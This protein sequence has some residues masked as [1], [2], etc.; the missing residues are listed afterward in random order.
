MY[1]IPYAIATPSRPG[2]RF[3]SSFARSAMVRGF[4]A[5]IS[6]PAWMIE[7]RSASRMPL[8]HGLPRRNPRSPSRMNIGFIP[9]ASRAVTRWIVLRISEMR[10]A[11][12]LTTMRE[13]SC[14]RKLCSRVQSPTY[15]RLGACA[16]MPTSRSMVAAAEARLRSRRSWRASSARFSARRSRVGGRWATGPFSFPLVGGSDPGVEPPRLGRAAD[17]FFPG[18]AHL[19][20]SLAQVASTLLS[21]DGVEEV[22]RG[23]RECHPHDQAPEPGSNE[24]HLENAPPG[25]RHR[26]PDRLETL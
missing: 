8:P 10:T 7:S 26:L 4:P 21:A 3:A 5:M 9:N 25:G 1:R 16:C 19:L 2:N 15:G 6:R 11:E 20:E 22:H 12:R 13:S 18:G 24:H 17:A 23:G 14:W